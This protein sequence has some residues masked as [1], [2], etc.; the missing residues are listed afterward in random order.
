M[1]MKASARAMRGTTRTWPTRPQ[2][3][4]AVEFTLRL[5]CVGVRV[6]PIPTMITASPS[7]NNCVAIPSCMLISLR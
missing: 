2:V 5:N 7:G 3:T 1:R 6:R 4:V